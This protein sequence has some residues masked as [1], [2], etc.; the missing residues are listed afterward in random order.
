MSFDPKRYPADWREFSRRI[1][2][3]RAKG[4]CECTGECGLHNG[5]DLVDPYNGRC[6]ELDGQPAKFATGTVMLTV[7][8]LNRKDGP[9]QCDPH[10]AIEDHVKA[11]CQRCHLRYDGERHQANAAE[12]RRTGVKTGERRKAR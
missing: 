2:Y 11:M 3:E 7:A 4:R 8:H 9:C 1:R 6:R 10:C 5:Q 12:T